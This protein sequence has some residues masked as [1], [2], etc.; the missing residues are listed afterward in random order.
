MFPDNP[1]LVPQTRFSL[2]IHVPFCSSKCGYCDFFSVANQRS[3]AIEAAIDETIDDLR[4]ALQL[5]SSPRGFTVPSV[6]IGGGTPSFLRLNLLDR[7]LDAIDGEL[8]EADREY[9]VEANPE[10]LT[11]AFLE[12]GRS[13]GVTRISVGVQSL[14]PGELEYLDRSATVEENIRA[15]EL[16]GRSY[17]NSFG[18]DLMSGVPG[19]SADSIRQA[20]DSVL[21]YHPIH[22]SFY[23]LTVEPG[24]PLAEQI[25]DGSRQAPPEQADIWQRGVEHIESAG[26]EWYEISNFAQP[27]HRSVHNQSYWRLEPYLGIG[28]GAV[29]TLAGPAGPVRITASRRLTNTEY[30]FDPIKP[31]EF[32]LE[33]FMMGLRTSDG[34]DIDRINRIFDFDFHSADHEYATILRD[35]GY[36]EMVNNSLRAT[37]S[38]R[39]IL[40]RL[41]SSIAIDLDRLSVR[42]PAWPSPRE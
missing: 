35:Q 16:V 32:L 3:N 1:T 24:T 20:I 10:S 11:D 31:S 17:A 7:L 12:R 22:L 33:H 39:M 23:S 40:D 27:G 8:P 9:T 42:R 5:I 13:R 41:L 38:G 34:L 21:S 19:Q 15:L 18:V 26:F 14:S 29:S 4:S 30:A 6:Y 36:L 25:E 28:P 37:R 2:Y